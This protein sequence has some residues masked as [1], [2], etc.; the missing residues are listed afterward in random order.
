MGATYIKYEQEACLCALVIG[1]VHPTLNAS[2]VCS[3][4]DLGCA[5]NPRVTKAKIIDS[6]RRAWGLSS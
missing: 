4:Q 3:P 6:P 2:G 5:S 1:G